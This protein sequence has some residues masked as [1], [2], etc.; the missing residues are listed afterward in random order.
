MQRELRGGV[1]GGVARPEEDAFEGRFVPPVQPSSCQCGQCAN[2]SVEEI[3]FG[4]PIE[5]LAADGGQDER[6]IS[7]HDQQVI[8]AAD[9]RAVPKAGDCPE[10]A[11]CQRIEALEVGRGDIL[12]TVDSKQNVA[13]GHRC[14]VLSRVEIVC[15]PED[16]CPRGSEFREHGTDAIT[17][18][19]EQVVSYQDRIGPV[20]GW[21]DGS[22]AKFEPDVASG[23]VKPDAIESGDDD[24]QFLAIDRRHHR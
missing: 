16:R 17:R 3:C 9:E 7:P 20:D 24:Q 18:R 2:G 21:P 22:E 13:V 23:G 15:P 12:P 11:L 14:T 4:Q 8:T 19:E 6:P 10:G 5:S 1:A